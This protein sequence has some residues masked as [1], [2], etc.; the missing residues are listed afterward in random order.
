MEKIMK[1]KYCHQKLSS[2]NKSFTK[3]NSKMVQYAK[4]LADQG[5]FVS[6][7]NYLTNDETVSNTD[8]SINLIKDRIYNLIDPVHIQQ[9]KLR[10]P[11]CP[12]KPTQQQQQLPQQ[13]QVGKNIS[14]YS[15]QEP[16]RSPNTSSINK[17]QPQTFFPNNNY[18]PQL[19]A[20]SAAP[21]PPP[22]QQQQQQ[23]SI[24]SSTS[25]I[26]TPFQPTPVAASAQQQQ[27]QPSYMNT[28]PPVA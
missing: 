2:S 27:M 8:P 10:K 11:D 20:V 6:A 21:L 9:F 13:Q 15:N 28:K 3:L 17:P 1:I 22:I 12:F 19:G 4:L 7:Y 24:M 16:S 23:N 26:F 25:T 18:Q 14:Y 5:S